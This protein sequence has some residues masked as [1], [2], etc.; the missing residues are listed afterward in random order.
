MTETGSA[1]LKWMLAAVGVL[2]AYSLL[3]PEVPATSLPQ[4]QSGDA[5]SG[6]EFISD[7]SLDGVEIAPD[8]IKFTVLG[9]RAYPDYAPRRV[10][11]KRA[12]ARKCTAECGSHDAGY[13]WAEDHHVV[14]AT[15]CTDKSLAFREGC[16]TYADER[17]GGDS[18]EAA[19][20]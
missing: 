15:S 3:P 4:T 20:E 13:Q 9:I 18:A 14:D 12:S 6:Q 19:A 8:P 10:S 7:V 17:G 1:G 11:T 5:M 2:I 16:E